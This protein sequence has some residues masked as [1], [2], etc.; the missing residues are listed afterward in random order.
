MMTR[1]IYCHLV[2]FQDLHVIS[3]VFWLKL[4]LKFIS[5]VGS[6]HGVM[7][8]YV[9]LIQRLFK[10]H[11][12]TSIWVILIAPIKIHIFKISFLSIKN[13]WLTNHPFLQRC[14]PQQLKVRILRRQSDPNPTSA[15]KNLSKN[16]SFKT[17]YAMFTSLP[18]SSTSRWEAKGSFCSWSRYFSRLKK[19]SKKIGVIR[20]R[21]ISCKDITSS[22][23]GIIISNI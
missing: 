13:A 17:V 2:K 1:M 3:C 18:S 7:I 5:T 10:L 23:F 6:Y 22:F 21:R 8:N 19:V 9:I 12:C 14:L 15:I 11:F 16:M 20:H 4:G